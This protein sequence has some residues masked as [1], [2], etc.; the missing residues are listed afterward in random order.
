LNH[1]ILFQP[2]AFYQIVSNIISNAIKY[3]DKEVLNLRICFDQDTSSL[4]FKDNGPGIEEISLRFLRCFK[5]W[6]RVLMEKVAQ[7]WD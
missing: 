1:T 5:L 4:S 7:V 2:V 6:V 3:N